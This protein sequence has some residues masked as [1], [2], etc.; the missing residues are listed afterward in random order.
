MNGLFLCVCV[1][2]FGVVVSHKMKSR[3][4]ELF[5]LDVDIVNARSV[6]WFSEFDYFALD[7]LNDIADV[8]L[9]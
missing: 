7:Y 9:Q 1:L 5:E 8:Q 4:V 2:L 3:F 6:V